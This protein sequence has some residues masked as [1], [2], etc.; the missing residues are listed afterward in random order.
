MPLWSLLD[1]IITDVKINKKADDQFIGFFVAQ[2]V[3]KLDY[4]TIH[5]INLIDRL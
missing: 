3:Q 5:A 4:C 2:I 1:G